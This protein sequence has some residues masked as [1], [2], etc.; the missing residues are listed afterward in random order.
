MSSLDA[1]IS[2]D[3]KKKEIKTF[4]TVTTASN[5][6]NHNRSFFPFPS[7]SLHEPDTL[8]DL[9]PGAKTLVLFVLFVNVVNWE[10]R[11]W[12]CKD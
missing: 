4:D 9:S 1:E 12:F 8:S 5:L 10:K 6:E 2:C 7:L 11:R 3:L